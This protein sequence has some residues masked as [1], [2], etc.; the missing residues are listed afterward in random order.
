MS[1][2]I[3][4][5]TLENAQALL[6]EESFKRPVL[7]DFWADWCAPCKNLMPVLE[8]LADEYAGQFLLAKVNSDELNMIAQQFGVR[9]L[10]TVM[11]M[12]DGQ[13]VDGFTGA[14]PEDQVRAVLDKHLPKPWDLQHEKA[15]GL[16]E[17][18]DIENAVCEL[19]DA[20]GASGQQ[21]N[22]ALSLAEA[23]VSTRRFDEAESV[24]GEIKMVDQ[25]AEYERVKAELNIA[26][27][28]QK[29]P[30]LQALED[31]YAKDSENVELGY[32][33][34]V[35]Y[36]QHQFYKES[37]DL[38]FTMLRRDMNAHEGE[39]KKSFMDTLALLGKGDPVAAEYQR[40]LYTLLY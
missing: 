13:P 34:A 14:Q 25:D 21:A 33:L 12:K 10:P 31:K 18:G 40:K 9:S 27:E 24:I 7:I 38:L 15:L 30:E 39:V 17:A 19:R 35:Q 23:L 32:T 5:I 26:R 2:H 16:I 20:Y 1:D 6:I 11:L 4:T 29:A 36:S 22:I 8:K 3:V 28:A 37:L